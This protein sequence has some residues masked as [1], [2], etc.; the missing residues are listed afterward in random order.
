MRRTGS[1]TALMWSGVITVS[2][3]KN[4]KVRATASRWKW[5]RGEMPTR[6][7]SRTVRVARPWTRCG[8][9]LRISR[10]LYCWP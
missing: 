4:A 9:V 10:T 3:W 1:A 8:R 5:T 6:M 2:P 7:Y